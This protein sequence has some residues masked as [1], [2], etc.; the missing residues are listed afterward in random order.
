MKCD[1]C[2]REAT[3]TCR[4]S[5]NGVQEVLHLCPVCLE[6]WKQEHGEDWIGNF[7]SDSIGLNALGTSPFSAFPA[8][9]QLFPQ[10]GGR[11]NQC[12]HSYGTYLSTGLLGCAHC[13]E[14]F[15]KELR[16]EVLPRVQQGLTYRG[17]RYGQASHWG[18]NPAES[19]N[20]AA[21]ER[22]PQGVSGT[23]DAE[24][25]LSLAALQ[26]SLKRAIAEERYEDAARLRDRI[27]VVQQ[28]EPG[29]KPG[30][31]GSDESKTERGGRDS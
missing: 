15:R 21:E 23:G 30:F 13:Y 20:G 28:Q 19:G 3:A 29:Q 18:K 27:R 16:T 24:D 26:E 7:L 31:V 1:R 17:R 2:H 11:C 12:G 6:R 22:T 9:L 25:S 8:S 10:A 14:A 4:Y 5:H